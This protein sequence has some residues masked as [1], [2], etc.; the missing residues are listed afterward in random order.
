[1][2]ETAF[3]ILYQNDRLVAINKPPGMLVHRSPLSRDRVFVLQALRDQLGQRLYPVHRLDRATSGALLFAL[4]PD[5]A[6]ELNRAFAAQ[7]VKKT[8]LAVVRGW[9]EPAAGLVDRPVRD[10]AR[11]THRE[12]LTRYRRLAAAELP[13]ANRRHATSRYSLMALEPRTG[14]RHQLRIH[15]ERISHP[16]IGDTTHGDGEHNRLFREHLG[17]RRLLLH[18]ASLVIPK[19]GNLPDG[20]AFHAPLRGEFAHTLDELGWREPDGPVAEA[21]TDSTSGTDST[22]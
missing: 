13:I 19:S 1:M 15:M 5:T 12:A 6:H 9:P 10:D 21:G 4:N 11:E 22:C 2:G 8:Y 14:R 16:I 18:A 3:E 7:Q 17:T 20:L